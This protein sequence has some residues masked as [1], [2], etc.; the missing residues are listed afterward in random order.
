MLYFSIFDGI[1]ILILVCIFFSIFSLLFVFLF[2]I[3]F[4]LVYE[5]ACHLLGYS[6][7]QPTERHL[8]NKLIGKITANQFSLLLYS[9]RYDDKGG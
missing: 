1:C 3:V 6:G 5:S 2:Q 4:L 9:I 8:L 7:N